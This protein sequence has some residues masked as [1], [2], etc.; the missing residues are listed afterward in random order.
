[1]QAQAKKEAM[2]RQASQRLLHSGTGGADSP[3]SERSIEEAAG[4]DDSL[5]ALAGRVVSQQEQIVRLTSDLNA[6]N[7]KRGELAKVRS[8]AAHNTCIKIT[9]CSMQIAAFSGTVYMYMHMQGPKC[10]QRGCAPPC[11]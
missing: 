6:A 7:A 4:D 5:A 11:C 2:R 3:V 9:C 8:S 10:S 1:L